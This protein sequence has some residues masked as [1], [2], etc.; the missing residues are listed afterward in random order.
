MVHSPPKTRE[1]LPATF[2]SGDEESLA[3]SLSQSIEEKFMMQKMDQWEKRNLALREQYQKRTSEKK[4]PKLKEEER[5]GEERQE[6]RQQKRERRQEVSSRSPEKGKTSIQGE[7]QQEEEDRKRASSTR[8]PRKKESNSAQPKDSQ[9]AMNVKSLERDEKTKV[10]RPQLRSSTS[11][12]SNVQSFGDKKAKAAADALKRDLEALGYNLE[13]H[14]FLTR[15]DSEVSRQNRYEVVGEGSEKGQESEQEKDDSS[16]SSEDSSEST[17]DE[18]DES[19]SEDTEE[20][21]DEGSS[22][23]S[24]SCTS[25]TES[26]QMRRK[27]VPSAGNRKTKKQPLR[28]PTNQPKGKN[29]SYRASSSKPIEE[30]YR[31]K[32]KP[33]NSKPPRPRSQETIERETISTSKKKQTAVPKHKSSNK[34]PAAMALESSYNSTPLIHLSSSFQPPPS[35]V[36]GESIEETDAG[37]V[38]SVIHSNESGDV[39]VSRA[40]S[41][42]SD[43]V[44][45]N[46]GDIAGTQEDSQAGVV[47]S[48][49][50]SND[51]G[52]AKV[53]KTNNYDNHQETDPSKLE[54]VVPMRTRTSSRKSHGSNAS[55]IVRS[56]HQSFA[57]GTKSNFA[58]AQSATRESGNE[59][60][61]VSMIRENSGVS[62]QKNLTRESSGASMQKNLIRESSGASKQK[63]STIKERSFGSHQGGVPAVILATK[64]DDSVASEKSS[65]SSLKASS[66]MTHSRKTD[67]NQDD[68]PNF[69]QINASAEQKSERTSD[70][71]HNN[72]RETTIK[73]PVFK[74]SATPPP[75]AGVESTAAAGKT[76]AVVGTSI[77]H[78]G[79]EISHGPDINTIEDNNGVIKKQRRR[80]FWNRTK[81][82]PRAE[83]EENPKESQ[84]NSSDN[85][86]DLEDSTNPHGGHASDSI[87]GPVPIDGTST[88][89]DGSETS[90]VHDSNII[91]ENSFVVKKNAKKSFWSRKQQQQQPD[92]NENQNEAVVHK[93]RGIFGG[94]LFQK[95]DDVQGKPK[96]SHL[97]LLTTE[98]EEGFDVELLAFTQKSPSRWGLNGSRVSQSADIVFIQPQNYSRPIPLQKERGGVAFNM[99]GSD[100]DDDNRFFDRICVSPRVSVKVD[101]TVE[102]K[103]EIIKSDKN[104]EVD[105]KDVTN[106]HSD[107]VLLS[108][109][110]DEPIVEKNLISTQPTTAKSPTATYKPQPVHMRRKGSTAL[111]TSFAD[112]IYTMTK[113]ES[114]V[115]KATNWN[116]TANFGGGKLNSPET[117][118]AR[119]ANR[120]V[121]S[122]SNRPVDYLG[123]CHNTAIE[124]SLDATA[125]TVG[126]QE[127]QESKQQI[128]GHQESLAKLPLN[129]ASGNNNASLN[130]DGTKQPASTSRQKKG[131]STLTS[132]TIL[133]DP[134][135]DDFSFALGPMSSLDDG[136][137]STQQSS[138]RSSKHSNRKN[139]SGNG[140]MAK[141]IPT[142]NRV[143]PNGSV[144]ETRPLPSPDTA[145]IN[146]P[147]FASRKFGEND[148][149][150]E[151]V[152]EKEAFMQKMISKNEAKP[153]SVEIELQTRS[154]RTGTKAKNKA[155]REPVQTGQD[156]DDPLFTMDR[157]SAQASSKTGNVT[158][159]ERTRRRSLSPAQDGQRSLSPPKDG[160]RSHPGHRMLPP[161]KGTNN[162]PL[163][164]DPAITYDDRTNSLSPDEQRREHK[165]VPALKDGVRTISMDSDLKKTSF[166]ND[167]WDS[168]RPQTKKQRE[169]RTFS[170]SQNKN[171]QPQI[172]LSPN[173]KTNTNAFVDDWAEVNDAALVIN[174]VMADMKDDGSRATMDDAELL[175]SSVDSSKT[176]LE[177]V[178]K[179]LLTLR[180]HAKKMGIHESDLLLVATAKSFDSDAYTHRPNT[181]GE[182]FMERLSS[183]LGFHK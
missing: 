146:G 63:N 124:C 51:S 137:R 95:R 105:E 183:F 21:N 115:A 58:R 80:G 47:P 19:T 152:K 130:H 10:Q 12:I 163:V 87:T 121:L 54:V 6:R 119:L 14:S 61:G 92:F 162:N 91:P 81:H 122:T 8:K 59:K 144:Y 18:C 1:R 16:S 53:T 48:V 67:E 29:D 159:E 57:R 3:S 136:A 27:D 82:Q 173:S 132:P 32:V 177:N 69:N 86:D 180:K 114:F 23:E 103:Q 151:D 31:V 28:S 129:T 13:C 112:F 33:G 141:G 175:L 22:S 46:S 20:D 109:P 68:R 88:I 106:D 93:K 74:K 15:H 72:D 154:K 34:T 43:V 42:I 153:S 5:R 176:N 55:P 113:G 118:P 157:K 179:A 77:I 76:D 94:A 38:S 155:S 168:P 108:D 102:K 56:P 41:K 182:D 128:Q 158:N 169:P 107:I 75:S 44:S 40:D 37:G 142:K 78:D 135:E 25:D 138:K 140:E 164:S 36:N 90:Q 181:P 150:E 167:D 11:A 4:E 71:S 139:V 123:F 45:N 170:S 133:L 156:E 30:S 178:E 116:N 174:R 143:S 165:S 2:V 148:P 17:D 131:F 104:D 79:S 145:Y 24:S 70:F 9:N 98:N 49:V 161:S 127:F 160:R 149:D 125:Q 66:D 126:S 89:H 52:D 73:S 39:E 84:R 97:Q 85:D 171:D 111:A 62:K 100:Y 35:D 99:P 147:N 65:T 96:M 7:G 120:Q 172:K 50:H 110:S 117:S 64:D 134:L 60:E 83:E 26:K 166:D 101:E